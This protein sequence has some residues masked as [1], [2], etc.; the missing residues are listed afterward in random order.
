MDDT[1]TSSIQPQE[2]SIGEY[3]D[4]ILNSKNLYKTFLS[5]PTKKKGLV[6]L[7]LPDNVQNKFA[8]KMK[9]SRIIKIL[10]YLDQVDMVEFLQAFTEEKK[11][12]ILAQFNS[13]QKK[14]IEFL[15]KFDPESAA[16]LMKIDFILVTP[17]TNLERIKSKIKTSIKRNKEA[18]L[19]LLRDTKE[20]ILGYIPIENFILDK[21]EDISSSMEKIPI[22][23]HDQDY[24]EVLDIFSETHSEFA[25]V[26]DSEDAILGYIDEHYLL[27]VVERRDTEELYKFAGV[28]KEEDI[29]DPIRLKIKSRYMWLII[30]LLTAFMAASVISFFEETLSKMVLLAVYL[31]IIAGMGGNAATQTIAVVIRGIVL[32][33]I[34]RTRQ[35][36]IMVNEIIAG[37]GNGVITGVIVGLVAYLWNDMAM[38][39]VVVFLSMVANLMIAGFFGTITPFILKRFNIDPAIAAT[40]FVTTA[41]DVLGFLVFLGLAEMLVI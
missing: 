34:D 38:L 18:P 40:V 29:L 25:V 20:N 10:K 32:H 36:K 15:L 5:V 1:N 22:V 3:C 26:V 11:G 17:N 9:V 6:F 35:F 7:N 24:N 13:E 30:N 31:P 23:R 33:E 2:I 16:G 28:K 37:L 14:K 41:T 8:K 4:L 27:R 12:R 39:G 19:I 21:P